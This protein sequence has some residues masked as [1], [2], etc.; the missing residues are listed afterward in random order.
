LTWQTAL[1]LP[2]SDF[3]SLQVGSLIS[4]LEPVQEDVIGE[5]SIGKM[6]KW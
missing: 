4:G 3:R 2:E 5:W 1:K 6:E